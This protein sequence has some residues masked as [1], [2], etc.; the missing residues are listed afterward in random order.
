[1]KTNILEWEFRVQSRKKKIVSNR[2][3]PKVALEDKVYPETY[4]S[5][6]PRSVI[7]D[8]IPTKIETHEL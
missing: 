8:K 5:H 4:Y 2:Y 7:V 3:E 1:V 6:Q